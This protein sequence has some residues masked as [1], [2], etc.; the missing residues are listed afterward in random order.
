M[1][2]AFPSLAVPS[3]L[4][5]EGNPA[6]HGN[7]SDLCSLLGEVPGKASRGSWLEDGLDVS[8]ASAGKFS[9]SP[10]S[11][12]ID[13]LAGTGSQKL[14]WLL[15]YRCVCRGHFPSS[16]AGCHVQT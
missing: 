4:R 13:S 6:H 2:S 8:G 10:H 11:I 14:L 9:I 16:R 7:G 15:S 3:F 5:Q 12:I 1:V